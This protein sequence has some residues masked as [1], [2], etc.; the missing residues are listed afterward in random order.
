M[1]NNYNVNPNDLK[2][3]KDITTDV[4][5]YIENAIIKKGH[6]PKTAS[7]MANRILCALIDADK[8]YLY[9]GIEGWYDYTIGGLLFGIELNR[10]RFEN[11][12]TP[13]TKPKELYDKPK[14]LEIGQQIKNALIN[15][16]NLIALSFYG[17]FG[18]LY[19]RG[20]DIQEI[21]DKI[22]PDNKETKIKIKE[23]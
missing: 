9:S 1:E 16:I 23:R 10:D 8:L 3:P 20:S 19:Y 13:L 12:Y 17:D 6:S 11:L 14:I 18:E 4:S 2:N 5:Q 15:Q 21:L 7:K 22:I